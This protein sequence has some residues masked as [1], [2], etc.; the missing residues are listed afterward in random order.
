MSTFKPS[1]PV[2]QPVDH[3]VVIWSTELKV[4]H[5]RF[6][7]VSNIRKLIS[8]YIIFQVLIYFLHSQACFDVRESPRFWRRLAITQKEMDKPELIKWLS[9][10][11]THSDRAD[12]LEALL[13]Q[14]KKAMKIVWCKISNR[15]K[16]ITCCC[17]CVDGV[18]L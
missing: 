9:T 8:P 6:T 5:Y 7:P 1:Y 14:V 18:L 13:P 4:I 16:E 2:T 17:E 15:Y 3:S 12:N 10:H 11:P